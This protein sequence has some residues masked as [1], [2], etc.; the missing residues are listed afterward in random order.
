MFICAH[1]TGGSGKTSIM[2]LFKKLAAFFDTLLERLILFKFLLFQAF[3]CGV[4]LGGYD[5]D[6]S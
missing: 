4:T 1:S 5:R 2:F 6:G 3:R